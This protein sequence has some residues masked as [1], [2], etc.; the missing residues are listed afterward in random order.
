[1]SKKKTAYKNKKSQ[2]YTI[3]KLDSKEMVRIQE[4]A[5]Y[6]ALKRIEQEKEQES[7][8][9]EKNMIKTGTLNYYLKFFFYMFII[10]NK[11]Q[12]K[13][14]LNC[15]TYDVLLSIFVAY[16]LKLL[17]YTVRIV[18]VLFAVVAFYKGVSLFVG[19][20]VVCI[21]IA[22]LVIGSLLVISG[23][24]FEKQQDSNSIYAYSA[25]FIALI[26]L[27]VSIISITK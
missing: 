5:Y 15:R 12:E 26:S 24:E 8:I 16:S 9:E 20:N 11:A 21:T 3:V 2:N 23:S 14:G 6:R 13:L 18:A 17:G 4:E 27:I 19:L 22:L 7:T 25:S 10:P 1:M